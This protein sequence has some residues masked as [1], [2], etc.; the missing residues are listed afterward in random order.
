M[1]C[2]C[3]SLKMKKISFFCVLVRVCGV[4]VFVNKNVSFVHVCVCVCVCASLKIKK[5]SFCVWR[6]YARACTCGV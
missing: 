4:C 1:V 3:A 2:V 5:F 6:V